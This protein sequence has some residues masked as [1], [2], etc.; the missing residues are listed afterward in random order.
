MENVYLIFVIVL[1]VLAVSDLIVGVSNDAVNFL[2][3][4]IGSKA[5][6]FRTIMIIAALGVLIGS[7]FSSGMMEVARK[8]IFHPDKYFF[9]EIM[10]IFLAV[11][12]T[13]VILLDLFNSLGLPTS[14]TVS[15]VFELLGG[16][17]GMAF[18]KV[19][20]GL[21]GGEN[22]AAFINT[23]KALMIIIGILASVF[24]AFTIGAIVQYVTRAM[25]S[26]NFKGKLKYFGAIWGGV[27]LTAIIYFIIFKGAKGASFINKDIVALLKENTGKLLIISFVSVTALLQILYW[28]FKIN[29]PRIIVLV[30]T[31]ALAM[32][33][34]GNDLV[35]FIGVPLAGFESFKEFVANGTVSANQLTMES[36]RDP[37][38]TPTFFLLIAGLIMVITL[39]FSKKAKSVVKTTINLSRQNDGYERFQTSAIARSLVRASIGVGSF[40]ETVLPDSWID[41]IRTRFEKPAENEDKEVAFDMIRASVNLVVAS[42]LIAFFTSKTLPLSTTYVTFMVAMGTSLADGAWDRESAVYRITGVITVIT[43]WFLTAATAFTAAFIISQVLNW[44]G[45]YSIF[46]LIILAV[47]FIYRTHILH[48]KREKEEESAEGV[49]GADT[50]IIE[51]CNHNIVSTLI[52]SNRLLNDNMVF[53]SKSKRKKLRK[54]YI[55]TN[56]LRKQVNIYKQRIGN[57]IKMLEHENTANAYHYVSIIDHL[58][59]MNDMLTNI[60]Y[61]SYMHIDNNHSPLKKNQVNSLETVADNYGKMNTAIVDMLTKKEFSNISDIKGLYEK[62]KAETDD[63][64]LKQ[65]NKMQD[66]K[67]NSTRGNILYL[68][69]LNNAKNL[70]YNAMQITFAYKDFEK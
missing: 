26:F 37:V 70:A 45:L 30:G 67:N 56:A 43:G 50:D 5:A 6:S 11:M 29:I 19:R 23:D 65:I 15:I 44:G 51:Y 33:F 52:A 1:F 66:K 55:A 9:N 32:A 53:L 47:F 57:T 39:W 35:N 18:I 68:D 42:T 62:F 25:F 13:D 63:L 69:I 58:K 14:T 49:L 2:N 40:F 24:I 28:L 7:T 4:A 22:I 16:A 31:F 64:R 21:A 60:V 3:S 17:V 41:K 54:T 12:I 20:N 36:L 34:A 27:A 59:E 61:P 10:I 8:G 48:R 46:A 38:K